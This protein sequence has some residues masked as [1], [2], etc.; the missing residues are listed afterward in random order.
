M[1]NVRE[2]LLYIVYNLARQNQI[3]TVNALRQPLEWLRFENIA[4]EQEIA[5]LADNGYLLMNSEGALSLSESGAKEA[6]QINSVRARAEFNELINSASGSEAYLDYCEEIYGY[7]MPLFNAMDKEQLD[8][9]FNTV[10]ISKRDRVL[11]LGCGAGCILDYLVRKYSCYGIGIDQLDEATVKRSSPVISYIEGDLDALEDYNLKPTLTLAVDSLYF[12]SNL[13]GLLKVLKSVAGNRLYLY[14][15]QYIFDEAKM[16]KAI[17][18]HNNTRLAL[19]LQESNLPYRVRDYSANEH[20][21][22]AKALE[23]LP[24]YKEAMIGEGNG[25]LYEKYQRESYSGK[26]MYDR[27]LASRYLYIVE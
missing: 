6:L 5:W 21:L 3:V 11:D 25:H 16:D 13:A 27:G 10:A 7:R 2:T 14:Y 12:S 20:A 23:I 17:L 22:Y 18:D 26:Q 8:Y 19:S 9:L 15:S 4:L 1:K 24:K